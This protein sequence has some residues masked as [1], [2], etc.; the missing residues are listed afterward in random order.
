MSMT[1]GG[2]GRASSEINITPMI[3]VLL[4]LL[5]IF[6]VLFPYQSKGERAEIPQP[7]TDQPITAPASPVVIQLKQTTDDQRPK[8]KINEQEVSWE[9]FSSRLEQIYSLRVDK[10]AFLKGDPEIDFQYVADAIDVAHRSGVA[11]IALMTK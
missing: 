1:F 6:M 10:V 4:V 5:I 3:D 8:L 11:R 2:R 9:N 7:A